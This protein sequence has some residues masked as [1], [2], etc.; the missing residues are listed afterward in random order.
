MIVWSMS[1][2]VW[3]TMRRASISQQAAREMFS[4]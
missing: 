3:W 4:S 2:G 1:A